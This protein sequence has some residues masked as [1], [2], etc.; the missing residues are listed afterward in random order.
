MHLD[1]TLDAVNCG[2]ITKRYLLVC[3]T[4]ANLTTSA[5]S[6]SGSGAVPSLCNQVR[7]PLADLSANT[8]P[9]VNPLEVKTQTLFLTTGQWVEKTNS[10]NATSITLATGICYHDV[11]ERPL[12]SATARQSNLYHSI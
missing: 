7:N 11:V 12:F 4:H 8:S 5:T 6:R 9:V 3:A 2:N 10:F 1:P